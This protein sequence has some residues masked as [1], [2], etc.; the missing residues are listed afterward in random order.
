MQDSKLTSTLI[1]KAS[2]M[3]SDGSVQKVVGWRKGLFDYDITPSVFTSADDLQ[4]NFVYDENCGA[5]LSKYLVK[6]TR[7]IETKK[8]TVRMNNKMAKQRDPN[9]QDQPIPSEKVLVFLKPCDTY[10]FTE[11][12]KENRIARD[13]VYAV[14]IPCDGMKIRKQ[15]EFLKDVQSAR[16]KSISLMTNSLVKKAMFWNQRDLMK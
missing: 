4:K 9:A 6:I 7:E 3:L 16:A 12:L 5:N 1:E 8:S 2:K 14:G 15:T 10:S 13:D 11:L